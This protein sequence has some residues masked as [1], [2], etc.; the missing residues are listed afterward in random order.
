MRWIYRA[1]CRMAPLRWGLF[2]EAEAY[3]YYKK[4][5]I[6]NKLTYNKISPG[7]CNGLFCCCRQSEVRIPVRRGLESGTQ[8][9]VPIF[10]TG[11]I[12]THSPTPPTS[13]LRAA[14]AHDADLL[15]YLLPFHFG[16]VIKIHRDM[17]VS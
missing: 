5:V 15:I 17:L 11:Y 13:T 16:R 12:P 10:P 7:T 4:R 8:P 14:R 6:S 3:A 1:I 2:A 9:S